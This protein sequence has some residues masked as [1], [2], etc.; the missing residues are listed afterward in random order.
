MAEETTGFEGAQHS[1]VNTLDGRTMNPPQSMAG[2][3]GGG[4]ALLLGC[5]FVSGLAALIY[6]TAWTRAF[7][8]VFGTSE[9]AIAT[10]LAA[11]M[12]GLAAGAAVAARLAPRIRRP[13]LAYGL[14]ELGIALAAL[15]VPLGISLAQSLYQALFSASGQPPGEG[16]LTTALFYLVC[17]FAI[18]LVPTGLMGATL[19][20]LA[21]HAVRSDAEVG[22]RIGLL[23]A[24]NTVGAVTGT[25]LAG[26]VLLPN[27]GLGNT[28]WIAVAGNALVFGIAALLA[29][30]VPAREHGPPAPRTSSAGDRRNWILPLMLGSGIAS[31]TYEVLWTR[32][33]GHVLGASVYAFATMLATFLTGIAIGSW[34]ASR[35]ATTRDASARGFS[36]AQLGTAGFALL[37]FQLMDRLPELSLRLEQSGLASRSAD[38]ALAALALLPAT[39]CIGATFPFAVRILARNE[40]DAGPGTARV[41]S[42]NTVGGIIG[43]VSAGFATLPYLGYVGSTV[44][45][46]GINLTLAAVAAFVLAPSL[47]WMA[48]L[49]GTGLVA[50]LVVPIDQPW[51]LIRNVPL[52]SRPAEGVLRFF[53]VGRSATITVRDQHGTWRMASNGLPE[54]TIQ[55]PGARSSLSPV[56]SWLGAAASMARPDAKTMLMVG[57]GGGTALEHVAPNFESIDVIEL[58]PA[59]ERANRALG[60]LR[61]KDVLADPRVTLTINDARSAML[62]TR[63]RYDA[64]VSQPSHPWTAGSSHLYTREFFELARSRL[65]HDGVFVQWMG[66]RFVDRELAKIL[67]ATLLEV[68]PNVRVYVP[69]PGGMLLLA[70]DSPLPLESEIERALALMPHAFDSLG[71][72]GP[73]DVAA[74]LALDEEGARRF[75]KGAAISSDD[76]NLLQTLSPLVMSQ[77]GH[78]LDPEKAF[79]PFEPLDP[80]DPRWDSVYLVRR[81]A[82]TGFR[83]RAR[84]L[85]GKISD[86]AQRNTA[87]ALVDIAENRIQD[88]RARLERAL[89]RDPSS[90]EARLALI[91][92]AP[93]APGAEAVL[94]NLAAGDPLT[95]ALLQG[96]ALE[97]DRDWRAVETLEPTLAAAHPHAPQYGAAMRLRA[98]WRVAS[99]DPERSREAL[100]LLDTMGPLTGSPSILLLRA[101]AAAQAGMGRGAVT[102][103]FELLGQIAGK[104]AGAP[105]AARALAVAETLPA[106]SSPPGQ[107][108]TLKRSL[109]LVAQGSPGKP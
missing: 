79:G 32:M 81:L 34:A 45:A 16:G 48:A 107:M 85:A 96:F 39:L 70:S 60:P 49:A 64:I 54:A 2:E 14:L 104:P 95:A 11:Y 17:S 3:G 8:F 109:R 99:N 21:R 40:A 90:Q 63:T 24:I 53:E 27:I 23:Y 10:V 38:A 105:L 26:F 106:N 101:K 50:L 37:A 12:G 80:N 56:G 103:L 58:E 62:L 76:F 4:F 57:L 73:T 66:L 51:R 102:S 20:L 84:R 19:P 31:F 43:A 9:L 35:M 89:T 86:D 97:E 7:A 22:S 33:L 1:V 52:A 67:V 74:A 82:Q 78:Y 65:T 68:F 71:I 87:R 30:R 44:L 108:S 28:V 25:I 98:Y 6:Q 59:V 47:R 18:L 61:Q 88:A 93:R 55:P 41:Y 42:W 46:V 15:A 83:R 36:L 91:Q 92:I 72:F 69:S 100:H 13:V 29:R 94:A 5:F 75:G 77:K